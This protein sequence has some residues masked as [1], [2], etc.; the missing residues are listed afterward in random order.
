MFYKVLEWNLN[1]VWCFMNYSA[2]ITMSNREL[3]QRIMLW[4]QEIKWDLIYCFFF[5]QLRVSLY[6]VF[7][8]HPVV[9][10]TSGCF[11]HL[12]W[13]F[14]SNKDQVLYNQQVPRGKKQKKKLCC[15]KMCLQV[16]FCCCCGY[17]ALRKNIG[18]A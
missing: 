13:Y 12:R 11:N 3:L 15:Y 18:S 16:F 1:V 4:R 7:A 5:S 8:L 2:I 14:G 17:Q 9:P 6:H 10:L